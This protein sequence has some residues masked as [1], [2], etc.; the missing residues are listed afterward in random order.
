[1]RDIP[2]LLSINDPLRGRYIVTCYLTTVLSQALIGS[3]GQAP[4]TPAPGGTQGARQ[5]EGGQR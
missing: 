1:V 2:G 4:L 3:A 5:T